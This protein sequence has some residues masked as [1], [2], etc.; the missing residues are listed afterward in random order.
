MV[1]HQL[2]EQVKQTQ[3]ILVL[4][5]HSIGAARTMDKTLL[6]TSNDLSLQA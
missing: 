3:A 4:V 5:T 1:L 6:L 2:R